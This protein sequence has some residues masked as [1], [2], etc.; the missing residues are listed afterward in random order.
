MQYLTVPSHNIGGCNFS[1]KTPKQIV[2]HTTVISN[3]SSK[4]KKKK[5]LCWARDRLT[6]THN[7]ENINMMFKNYDLISV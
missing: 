3:S 2:I 5:T 4:K 7:N 1:G 6:P